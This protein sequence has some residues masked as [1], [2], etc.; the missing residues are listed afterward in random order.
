M[1]HSSSDG[2]VIGL[3][4]TD[5][6]MHLYHEVRGSIASPRVFKKYG[7]Q[8]GVLASLLMR[9]VYLAAIKKTPEDVALLITE[10]YHNVQT[11]RCGASLQ[12]LE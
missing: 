10:F 2:D 6:D 9:N 11:V 1:T 5:D 8:E 12:L 7:R 4:D 3:L